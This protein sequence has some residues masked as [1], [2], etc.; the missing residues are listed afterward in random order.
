[1]AFAPDNRTVATGEIGPKPSIYV[2]DGPSKQIKHKLSGK[3]QKGIQAIAFSPSGKT[4]AAVAI[5]VD[6]CVAVYNV[7]TG[8]LLATDKG[9]K[10]WIID[11]SF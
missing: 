1:M 8:A 11:I 6:H 7:E 4:L 10:A 2:W 5:D 9:D 3:L